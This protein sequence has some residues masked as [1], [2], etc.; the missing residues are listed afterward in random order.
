MKEHTSIAVILDRSGSME[1]VAQDTIG[2]FNTFLRQQQD[3]PD[4]A[5]ISLYQFDYEYTPVYESVPVKEAPLLTNKTY[6]PRGSTALYDAVGRTVNALG[7][8][9]S[10]L[11]E[12]ERPNKV[13]VIIMTDGHENAS[14][15]FTHSQIE[16]MIKKQQDVY[17]WE[18]VYIGATLDAVSVG[19]GLGVK[20]GSTLRYSVGKEDATFNTVNKLVGKYRGMS[21][22]EREQLTSGNINLVDDEDRKTVL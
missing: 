8:R 21:A 3:A 2:G 14:R 4:D 12:N 19:T 17:S 9:F 7:S 11:P 18:F 10:S 6:V 20:A 15:E 13:M 1:F 16:S 22:S 5:D